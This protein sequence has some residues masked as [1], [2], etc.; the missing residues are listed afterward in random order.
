MFFLFHFLFLLLIFIVWHNLSGTCRPREAYRAHK[1][2]TF[3]AKRFTPA[4][5]E[6]LRPITGNGTCLYMETGCLPS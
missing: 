2:N 6:F 4:A 1:D 5:A 3:D